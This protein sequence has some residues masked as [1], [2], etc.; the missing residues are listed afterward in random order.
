MGHFEIPE[1]CKL[2]PEPVDT[3]SNKRNLKNQPARL[4]LFLF[5]SWSVRFRVVAISGRPR[6]VCRVCSSVQG[7]YVLV[8]KLKRAYGGI[9]SRPR[10]TA[11]NC[12]HRRISLGRAICFFFLAS[13]ATSVGLDYPPALWIPV[14]LPFHS[15]RYSRGRDA[16]DWHRALVIEGL[17]NLR[18]GISTLRML[19]SRDYRLHLRPANF[20]E[21]LMAKSE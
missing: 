14:A 20:R 12:E 5:S 21:N 15:R 6:D 11:K 10:A 1:L 9:M 16:P 4:F 13:P 7:R 8:I 3:L 17:L 2:Y 18:G 19:R